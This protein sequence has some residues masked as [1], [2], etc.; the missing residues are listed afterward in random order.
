MDSVH[1][2]L[3]TSHSTL[4]ITDCTQYRVYN[5]VAEVG[6]PGSCLP[7]YVPHIED[8]ENIDPEDKGENI[9]TEDNGENLDTEYIGAN[10]DNEDNRDN[11]NR[12]NEDLRIYVMYRQ[13]TLISRNKYPQTH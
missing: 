12:D 11:D 8:T 1:C 6:A 7:C 5:P 13:T 4:H 3:L 10:M 9:N 2:L